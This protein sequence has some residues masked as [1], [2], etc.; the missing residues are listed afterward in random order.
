MALSLSFFL[1][2]SRTRITRD[3]LQDT[4]VSIRCQLRYTLTSLSWG[5]DKRSGGQ[6]VRY[7]FG[8]ADKC[9]PK[10]WANSQCKS[11][12]PMGAA[13]NR[14][15]AEM[16]ERAMRLHEQFV[17]AG[18]FPAP[19][20]FAAQIVQGSHDAAQENDF[21]RRY[22]EY[23]EFLGNQGNTPG[24]VRKHQHTRDTLWKFQQSTRTYLD[25]P[26]TGRT[27]AA[28]FVKWLSAQPRAYDRP[29][30]DIEK[31]AMY[32]LRNLKHF[33]NHAL[34]E[35]WSSSMAHKQIK[36]SFRRAEPFPT[37]LTEQE[38]LRLHELPPDALPLPK[39]KQRRN[40][41]QTRDWFVFAAQTGMR[42]GNWDFGTIEVVPTKSGGKNIRFSQVK[43]I[44][45]LEVPLSK[46][47]LEV[48]GRNGGTMPPKF[49]PFA[50]QKHLD[51]L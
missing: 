38:L 43:T 45:P 7:T 30:Q 22:A 26:E 49:S 50:T 28:K 15:M 8:L 32:H 18:R 31:T 44:N 46:M 21:W 24:T 13:T 16:R 11:T 1:A 23:I 36:L 5:A 33:L 40:V 29:G 14:R 12:W 10:M 2:V 3:K 51:L 9:P 39:G 27:F 42:Y 34:A 47:A 25:F 37:T 35:G 41:L 4:P 6:V 19:E 48:L 20:Q 17:Q